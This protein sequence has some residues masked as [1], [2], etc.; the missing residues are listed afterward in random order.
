[1][2]NFLLLLLYNIRVLS[3]PQYVTVHHTFRDVVKCKLKEKS[4]ELN[5]T[6]VFLKRVDRQSDYLL[7]V[8]FVAC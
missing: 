2:N 8:C 5:K 3:I 4:P 6:S 7:S 1:M